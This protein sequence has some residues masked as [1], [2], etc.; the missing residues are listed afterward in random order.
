MESGYSSSFRGGWNLKMAIRRFYYVGFRRFK[1]MDSRKRDGLSG[2]QV[3]RRRFLPVL[4]DIGQL[5]C[6][7][8]D[9]KWFLNTNCASAGWKKCTLLVSHGTN[10][11]HALQCGLTR[12]K[13][14]MKAI[15]DKKTLQKL[16]ADLRRIPLENTQQIDEMEKVS[17]T[18]IPFSQHTLWM[19][20]I[21]LRWNHRS[22]TWLL[23]IHPIPS[24]ER[25]WNVCFSWRFRLL[26][27]LALLGC[28][29]AKNAFICFKPTLLSWC[30]WINVSLIFRIIGNRTLLS[31]LH[32]VAYTFAAAW[33]MFRRE[34]FSIAERL[35][36][37][38]LLI[39]HHGA[40]RADALI[41]S[42]PTSGMCRS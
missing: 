28:L 37:V 27:S 42:S 12:V 36:H 29:K 38:P 18:V 22:A 1:K 35:V 13:S 32:S 3:D 21:S 14:V 8:P 9:Q 34:H 33:R 24:K 6:S 20:R 31:I 26:C 41:K 5:A 25:S 17:I 16:L 2:R 40:D 19:D 39:V 11:I 15:L 4:K 10:N 23:A 30:T 7:F